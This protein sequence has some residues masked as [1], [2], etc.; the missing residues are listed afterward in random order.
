MVTRVSEDAN[1]F[2]PISTQTRTLITHEKIFDHVDSLFGKDIH[3]KRLESLV[4]AVHGTIESGS[5]AI[6]FIGKGLAKAKHLQP[7]S[8]I[9]QA[10]RLLSNPKL[11]VDKLF[12]D[13]VPYVI[14]ARKEIVIS[15][16]WTEF[17]A[18]DQ[19]SIVLSVQ[20]KHG[21]N[22][23]LLWKTYKRLG[24]KGHRN[25]YEDALLCRL[26]ELVPE[27]VRVTIVA[28]RGFGD[29]AL[30]CFLEDELRFDYI[31]RIKGNIQ[32][33]DTEGKLSPVSQ[34]LLPSGRTRT[35]K[36]VQLTGNRQDV[37]RIICCQKKD[38]KDAWYIAASRRDL[39]SDK[40]LRMYG[41]RWGIETSFRDIKDYRF[42]MGMSH[43]R[44][45]SPMKRDRLFLLSAVTIGLLSILGQA[46]EDTG[47][48]RRFK[49]STSKVRTYS[50]FRQGCEYYDF[51]PGMRD[52]WAI[53]LMERF[54]YLLKH[55]P[56]YRS[57]FSVI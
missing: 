44:T 32:V 27:D 28:D 34:F 35:L 1:L 42:G 49:A 5:L 41:K 4:D 31:I 36:D 30:F 23:P 17:D 26:R 6:H 40:L 50:L 16:D 39:S 19:S 55:Q 12:E 54:E 11:N 33:T 57:V 9:K 15:L 7:K 47:L 20:T 56:F 3:Q 18:D 24:M 2:R 14:G 48:D 21:R 51:L 43:T 10:D 22:T 29:T 13:W 37:A 38:M 46:G 45:R 25:D 8:A 52:E 53:P